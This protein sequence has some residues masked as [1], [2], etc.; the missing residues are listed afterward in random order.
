M[1]E[2][3]GVWTAL[4]TPFSED[5][6][7]DL[8][9]YRMLLHRQADAGITGV[10]PCGTTAEAPALTIEEKKLL[11]RVALDE[12]AG[13][14][15]RVI[16]GTG[17]NNAAQTL[18]T[19]R[20][21]SDQGVEA[22][23]VVTPYYNK[24]SQAGLLTH[25][26][27]VAD[28]VDCEVIPYNVPS[29]TGVS[30]HP[31]TIT[32]LASHPRITALKEATGSVSLASDILDHLFVAGRE[33]NL[34]SGDD[35]TF[36]PFLCVGGKGVISVTSN[37]CPKT[38]TAIYDA[39]KAGDLTLARQL[40]WNSFPLFRDLFLECNPV[41]IKYAMARAGLCGEH[42]RP[43]LAPLLQ[44]NAQK[45]EQTLRECRVLADETCELSLLEV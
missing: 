21:A 37:L 35:A 18:E 28:A 25:F 5:G 8:D 45:L 17:S 4:V 32:K 1:A 29:R 2:I 43:P 10:I 3:E 41:P 15:T 19:S 33:L 34:L 23:L 9:A 27:S 13:T 6:S 42:V 22:V 16:A 44:E 14:A 31:E 38:M 12:L 26:F 24:P 7:L 11:I 30:L 36:F 40:H 39:T 20:W